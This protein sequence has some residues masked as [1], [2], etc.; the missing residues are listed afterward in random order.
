MVVRNRDLFG[1]CL[2]PSKADPPLIVHPDA[3]LTSSVAAELL[4]SIAR[5]NPKVSKHFCC[6]QDR[7]LSQCDSLKIAV[8]L[9]D[10]GPMPD[11]FGVFVSE[12]LQHGLIITGCVMNAR[13]YVDRDLGRLKLSFEV[14]MSRELL[15]TS[16][17]REEPCLDQQ[18][19]AITSEG[20]TDQSW[21]CTIS[22]H[23]HRQI[24]R[25][26]RVSTPSVSIGRSWTLPRTFS[27]LEAAS[28]CRLT[29]RDHLRSKT[30]LAGSELRVEPA[31]R[32]VSENAVLDGLLMRG[33]ICGPGGGT[34]RWPIAHSA[35]VVEISGRRSR[36]DV[37][38]GARAQEARRYGSRR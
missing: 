32:L 1:P 38:F 10:P 11:P 21:R 19:D 14:A 4:E 28:V 26:Q 5:W 9:L 36:D 25:N 3:V 17:S 18:D 24:A 6:V 35:D 30:Q 31:L 7:E 8:E 33:P 22:L 13:R 20:C 15:A 23:Q 29:R 37:P 34:S 27:E 16:L 12:R 2:R